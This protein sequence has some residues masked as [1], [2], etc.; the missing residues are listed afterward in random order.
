MVL[1]KG[2]CGIG[3]YIPEFDKRY[4]YR[5]SDFSISVLN[6]HDCNNNCP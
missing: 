1:K 6:R 4:G 2:Q 5:V 3:I